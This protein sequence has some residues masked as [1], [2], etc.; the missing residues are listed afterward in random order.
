MNIQLSDHFTFGRLLRFT[1]PSIG[2]MIFTSL[3]SVVDGFF[4][5]NFAG[6]TSFAAVNLIIPVLMISSSLGFMIGAGGS[7][8]VAMLF[9][10]GKKEKANQ[11]F[12]LLVF[13]NIILGIIITI[14][15]FLLMEKIVIRFGAEGKLLE[16]AVLYG[17]IVISCCT[18]YMLQSS[19]QTFLIVAEKPKM[20]L[21]LTV[22]AGLTNM[23]LDAVFVGVFKWGLV[24]AAVAT[25]ISQIVGGAIPLVY[26]LCPN[27][28]SL[29]I[30]KFVWNGKAILKTFSNGSSELVSNI[31]MSVVSILYNLQLLKIAGENGI[32]TYGV[33]MYVNFIFISLIL[34]YGIGRSPIVSYHYGAENTAELKNLFKKDVILI[35]ASGII[36]FLI[37]EFFGPSF[38]RIFTGG[39]SE[40]FAMSKNAFFIFSFVYFFVGFSILG[41]SFFTALNNGLISALIS[42]LRTLVFQATAISILPIFLGLNGIWLSEVVAEIASFGVTV[43]CM[44]LCRKRY[45]YL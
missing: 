25:C 36:L 32:A 16:D 11:V 17:R 8:L 2:M 33:L 18:M 23:I 27:K 34:G 13:M 21:F 30:G 12:S 4:V 3:Y 28:T 14:L 20:G 42:F 6:K 19:F 41:S 39:D 37:A 29:K 40:L 7:A 9:G 10:A 22:S 31:A 15:A 35:F 24:G 44:I 43:L 1:F 38:A 45:G 26:F 5:S